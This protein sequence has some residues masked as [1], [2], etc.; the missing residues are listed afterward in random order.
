[1]TEASTRLTRPL[2]RRVPIRLLGSMS[3]ERSLLLQFDSPRHQAGARDTMF[4]S[5]RS[6]Q[7]AIGTGPSQRGS[8]EDRPEG[9]GLR[10]DPVLETGTGDSRA[11]SL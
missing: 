2:M 10:G 4:H 3:D 6:D 8:T 1:M 9:V 7:A 11:V 5:E